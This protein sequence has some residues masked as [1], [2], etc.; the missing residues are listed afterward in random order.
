MELSSGA[1]GV[2]ITSELNGLV[3]PQETVKAEKPSII[4]TMLAQSSR[5]LFGP[6]SA[7][8]LPLKHQVV[9]IDGLLS[10]LAYLEPDEVTLIKKPFSFLMPRIWGNIAIAVNLTLPIQ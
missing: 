10:K 6:T 1:I 7:P 2:P 3:S 8:Q 4:A 9:S 5:H